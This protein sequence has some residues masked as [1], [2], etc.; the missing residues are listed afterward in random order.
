MYTI[1][2]LITVA[3]VL[4]KHVTKRFGNVVAIN[5]L[6]L[7]AKDKEFLVLACKNDIVEI[8]REEALAMYHKYKGEKE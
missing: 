4:L 1:Q 8:T 6:S 3:R 5:K 2:W 7:E